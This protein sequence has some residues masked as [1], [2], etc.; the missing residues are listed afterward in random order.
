[1]GNSDR[2]FGDTEPPWIK[3]AVFG[4]NHNRIGRNG[5]GRD[6]LWL[7]ENTALS[8]LLTCS[9]ALKLRRGPANLLDG[10]AWRRTLTPLSYLETIPWQ[11]SFFLECAGVSGL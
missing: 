10:R 11:V 3:C 5:R 9:S 4:N 2:V 8:F 7:I 1:M 6:S